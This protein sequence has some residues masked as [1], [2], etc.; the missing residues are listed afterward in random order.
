MFWN[1]GSA[2][3]PRDVSAV[4]IW[5]ELRTVEQTE[6]MVAWIVADFSRGRGDRSAGCHEQ[7]VRFLEG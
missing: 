2:A 7:R 4:I 1:R 5:Q 6:L 3:P